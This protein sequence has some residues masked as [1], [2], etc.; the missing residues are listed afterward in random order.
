MVVQATQVALGVGEQAVIH[1]VL[2]GGALNLQGLAGQV[3]QLIHAG[4]QRRL[5]T[6]KQVTQARHVQS[7]YPNGA[8]QLS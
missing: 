7:N 1:V 8:G 6:L 5:V 4:H 3:D 2:D